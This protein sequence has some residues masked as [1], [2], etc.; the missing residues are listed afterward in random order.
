MRQLTTLSPDNFIKELDELSP[1]QFGALPVT[2]LQ[3]NHLIADTITSHVESYYWCNDCKNRETCP[4]IEDETTVWITPVAQWQHEHGYEEQLGFNTSTFGFSLGASHLFSSWLHFSTGAGYSH[5]SL[6]WKENGG[7]GSWDSIY[8]APS[9]GFVNKRWYCN[10]LMQGSFNYYDI[11]REICF[12]GLARTARNHH[13][14]YGV[15]GRFDSGYKI[16][17]T[18]TENDHPLSVIPTF[19]LSYLNL[20]EEGYTESGAGSINLKVDPKYS[21]FLQPELLIK[22]LK[23]VYMN[24]SCLST[25]LYLGYV[26]NVQLSSAN[27]TSRFAVDEP[28]CKSDFTVR[29]FNKT[30]NQ[31]LVGVNL[32]L[33][34]AHQFEIGLDYEGRF[35]DNLYINSARFHIEKKF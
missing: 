8:L 2:E 30:T 6:G 12:P 34:M 28:F 5:T 16:T 23:E 24:H 29:S 1:S 32:L 25:A 20:F 15:L 7:K 33:K 3:N 11:K 4:P 18:N 21:A 13:H 31:L 17:F 10:F 27:Y 35:F 22:L 26:S 9:I 19:R 14:S